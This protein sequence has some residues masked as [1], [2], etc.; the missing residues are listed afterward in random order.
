MGRVTGVPWFLA[1]VASFRCSLDLVSSF[2][3]RVM[4]SSEPTISGLRQVSEE[5]M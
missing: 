2:S 5:E 3:L 1:A 4:P